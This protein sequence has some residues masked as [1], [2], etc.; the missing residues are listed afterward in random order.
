M[1]LDVD[2]MSVIGQK[3][4]G[5]LYLIDKKFMEKKQIAL[6][7]GSRKCNDQF[8]ARVAADNVKRE[9]ADLLKEAKEASERHVK[10]KETYK[11]CMQD[12]YTKLTNQYT[13]H[14][15]SIHACFKNYT[16]A[17]LDMLNQVSKSAKDRVGIIA[18]ELKNIDTDTLYE[19]YT[20]TL[21]EIRENSEAHLKIYAPSLV[22]DRLPIAEDYAR[23]G[24][25]LWTAPD[26][27]KV[28]KGILT[29]EEH[30]DPNDSVVQS[31]LVEMF[32]RTSVVFKS[33]SAGSCAIHHAEGRYVRNLLRLADSISMPKSSPRRHHEKWLKRVEKLLKDS[34]RTTKKA[35]QDNVVL[36]MRFSKEYL[37]HA[38]TFEMSAEGNNVSS[39]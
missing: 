8:N 38:F 30:M 10:A 21:E 39:T 2:S 15:K 27:E 20:R 12:S 22:R 28:P 6:V 35:I 31:A 23:D 37:E 13:L 11:K 33:M 34:L 16:K 29:M 25:V 18:E 32:D 3:Y 1:L 36:N 7:F 14:I 26:A 19:D 9:E 24:S 4:A 17:Q 5:I